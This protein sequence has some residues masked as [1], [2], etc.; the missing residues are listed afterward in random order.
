MVDY[1]PGKKSLMQNK[2]MPIAAYLVLA[3]SF[4]SV[5]MVLLWIA[6][7]GEVL[8][9]RKPISVVPPVATSETPV[10]L[11][12]D[13]CKNMNASGTIRISFISQTA[14]IFQP[15]NQDTQMKGCHQD[16]RVPI[17]LPP[18]SLVPPGR[19]RIKFHTVYNINP[20]K[21]V[22]KDFTTEEFTIQ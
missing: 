15:Q 5:L 6:Q 21:T 7:P 10:V 2:I 1:H 20:L 12:F 4:V 9:I 14:E 13:Y 16:T 11:S 18:A 22:T 8:T 3:L 17:L 19:Y